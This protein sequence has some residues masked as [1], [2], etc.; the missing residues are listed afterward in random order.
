MRKE[1]ADAGEGAGLL[2]FVRLF[3]NRPARVDFDDESSF[4]P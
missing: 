1:Q 3:D 4:E 2:R